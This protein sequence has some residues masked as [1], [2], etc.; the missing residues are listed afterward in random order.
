MTGGSVVTAMRFFDFFDE[1]SRFL[2]SRAVV[3]ASG[4]WSIL[5]VLPPDEYADHA[6]DSYYTNVGA[7]FTLNFTAQLANV[8]GISD[9]R[10]ETYKQVA[11]QL[12]LLYSDQMG[13]HLEYDNYRMNQKIKQAGLF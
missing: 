10:F 5:D 11:S 3:N 6:N 13:V 12:R 8:L 9:P 2:L 7:A 4:G 1:M